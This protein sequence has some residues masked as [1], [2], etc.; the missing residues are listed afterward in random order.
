MTKQQIIVKD[1]DL[2]GASYSLGVAEQRVIFLAIIEAR[3]QDKLIDAMGLLRI[4]AKSYQNQFNVGKQTAY[5]A[6]KKAVLGLFYA[7]LEY[8][9]TDQKTGKQAHHKIRWVE[10]IAYIDDAA[11]VDLQFTS[12]I[13][14]LI[15][16]L[17]ERYTEYELK[18]ISGLRSEY[19]IRLYELL[20][21]WRGVGKVPNMTLQDLRKKLGVADDK[22]RE[23]NDL[24]KRVIKLA[25]SQI[26]E[27]TDLIAAYHQSKTGREVTGIS[28]TF[29]KKKTIEHDS[30]ANDGFIKL[31]PSQINLFSRKLAALHELGSKAPIGASLEQFATM[32]ADDLAHPKRQARYAPYLAKV[33][34]QTTKRKAKT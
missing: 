12:S 31:T 16:R 9:Q 21:Q 27:H 5:E 11:C 32:I 6:L 10:H 29:K 34:Y 8:S 15:T 18:Q 17:K 25:I 20:S 2:I 26:N 4:S 13:I 1:N 24:K 7:E 33:G 19:S 22:Y 3:E 23:I 30:A 28:F 14:P